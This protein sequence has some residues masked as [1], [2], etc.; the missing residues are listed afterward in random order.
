M[1]SAIL[2]STRHRRRHM[3]AVRGV[4]DALN[5]KDWTAL[6]ALLTPDFTMADQGGSE[7]SGRDNMLAELKAFYAAAG[8][9][10]LIFESIDPNR[11]EVLVRG[12][13]SATNSKIQSP[14]MWRFLFDGPHI[15]RIEV[16]RANGEMTLPRFAATRRA[17]A[18]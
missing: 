11:D 5:S 2:P 13:F 15:C 16:T 7:I 17:H 14:T 12:S 9:P 18:A 3:R 6:A 4:A 1:F 10:H 8:D